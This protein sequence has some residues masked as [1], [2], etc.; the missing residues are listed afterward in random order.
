MKNIK[1]I[2]FDAYGKL[3]DVNSVAKKCKEKIGDK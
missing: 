1:S 2:I 3:F